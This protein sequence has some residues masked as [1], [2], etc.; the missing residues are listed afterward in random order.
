MT[1]APDL[2]AWMIGH[3]RADVIQGRPLP[4]GLRDHIR[5]LLT[6]PTLPSEPDLDRREMIEVSSTRYA[7][8]SGYTVQHIRR[9]CR[10]GRLPARR[11]GRDWLI[12][13]RETHAEAH[14]QPPA[15]GRAEGQDPGR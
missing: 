6:P 12:A 3:A 4:A 15:P 10:T 13:T 7:E 2:A 9:L 14:R 11:A 5:H 1:S 8:L